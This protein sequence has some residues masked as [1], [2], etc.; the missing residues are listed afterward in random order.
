MISEYV[1]GPV[2]SRRF[3]RSLG[4]NP[5]PRK[6]CNY[7][8]VY[9][10]L[11]RTPKLQAERVAL[12]ETAEVIADVKKAIDSGNEIDY[13]TFM[14]DGEPTIALNLGEMAEG[15]RR[16]WDGKMALITNGSMFRLSEVRAAASYFDV[17]SPTVSAG[18]ERTFRRLHRPPRSLKLDDVLEG[19]RLL[20]DE[21][22]GQIWAELMLVQEVN[23]SLP[24]LLN[25][26]KVM[27]Q[28]G[29]DRVYVNAPIRPPAESWV[30]PPTKEAL[31]QVFDVFPEAIDM[32][33]P[34]EGPF[35]RNKEEREAE[36]VEIAKNHP[37]REDQALELLAFAMGE[38]EAREGLRR[39]VDT[40]RLRPTKYSGKTFYSVPLDLDRPASDH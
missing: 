34:E 35:I 18:D 19:L 8:C 15:V 26:R 9:C 36:L 31:Q 5:L 1:F 16:F 13:V 4:V 30:R 17:I 25:I 33:G 2:P 3:G 28:V 22:H 20:R 37:L 40:G 10:Q 24:S 29:A 32:T 21:Y 6:T 14:G 7:S 23:D 27:R 11:G 12:Y 39:L 38:E